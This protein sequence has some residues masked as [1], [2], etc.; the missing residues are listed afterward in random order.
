MTDQRKVAL[1]TGAARGIGT[2][3][4]EELGRDHAVAF[5][6]LNSEKRAEALLETLDNGLA[7]PAD[8]E[9]ENAAGEII[10]K[11][12]ERFGRL[13]V[14]VNNASFASVSSIIEPN[15]EQY[16]RMMDI[17]A[18]A[19]MRLVHAALP[20]LSSGS[21]VI[22]ISSVNAQI[23][24]AVAGAFAASKAALEAFTISAAK[25]L[26]GRGIRVNAIAPG[27]IEVDDVERPQAVLDK[28]L[29]QTALGR[30]GAVEEIATTVRFLATNASKG[31]TGE[32]LRVAGGYGR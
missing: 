6:Y 30:I 7:L 3:I 17:N 10:G 22:N 24:P 29:P 19:P 31:I 26:G 11:T 8:L 5:T 15:F 13:D 21:S 28:Y 9:S 23:P 12:I 4:A 20:H 25:E 27:I 32:V 16:K 18:I 14:I 1:I 2:A